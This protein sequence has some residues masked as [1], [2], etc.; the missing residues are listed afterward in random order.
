MAS[1]R[2]PVTVSRKLIPDELVHALAGAG[3]N[4]R[5]IVEYLWEHRR[6]AVSRQAVAVARRRAGG[7]PRG[8]VRV[9]PW[10]LPAWAYRSEPARAI[11]WHERRRLAL[12]LS[13]P[14]ERRL[15]R[16]ERYLLEQGDAVWD[17]VGD[18]HDGRWRTVPRRAGIDTGLF[19]APDVRPG[20]SAA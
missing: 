18:E 14:D 3:L 9:T 8:Q 2:E 4:D 17:W 20:S 19:R 10:T 15:Q 7:E 6:L 11:R 5:E 16:M 12:P 1:S 13:A